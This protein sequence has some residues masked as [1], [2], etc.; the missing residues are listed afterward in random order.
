LKK[1]VVLSLIEISVADPGCLSRILIFSIPYPGYASKNLTILTQKMVSKLSEIWFGLCIPDPVP[2][3]LPILDPRSRIQGSKRHR[4]P[5]PGS[6]SAT[7]IEIIFK[8]TENLFLK[9]SG[10]KKIFGFG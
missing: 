7:L 10:G 5:D 8:K 4:I 3:F 1:F 2:D 9:K 6:G